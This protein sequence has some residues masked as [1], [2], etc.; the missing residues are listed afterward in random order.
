MPYGSVT[1]NSIWKIFW[2]LYCKQLER[3]HAHETGSEAEGAGSL[4]GATRSEREASPDTV[5]DIQSAVKGDY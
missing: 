4:G 5:D 3:D 2:T 1:L